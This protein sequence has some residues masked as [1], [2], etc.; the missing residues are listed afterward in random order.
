M[1]K[2]ISLN[3]NKVVKLSWIY[4]YIT[5]LLLVHLLPT[6][7]ALQFKASFPLVYWYFVLVVMTRWWAMKCQ[8]NVWSKFW[9]TGDGKRW[10]ERWVETFFEDDIP[11]DGL[12]VGSFYFNLNH[13]YLYTEGV[14]DFE[15][16]NSLG[17][18]KAKEL[19][20]AINFAYSCLA[21]KIT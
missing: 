3:N 16:Q 6:N 19:F 15:Q 13:T 8:R 9:V 17:Y 10:Y 7:S 1:N 5:F 21:V 12:S 4:N 18:S 2:V 11:N 20:Y 14:V